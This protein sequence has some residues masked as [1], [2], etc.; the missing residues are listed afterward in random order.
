M[1]ARVLEAVCA[2]EVDP[3]SSDDSV[4]DHLLLPITRQ[5]I[6]HHQQLTQ[7]AQRPQSTLRHAETP[8]ELKEGVQMVWFS[9]R[10]EW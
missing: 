1:P 6:R 8:W 3:A 10:V 4:S 5:N 2:V 9:V 7:Y